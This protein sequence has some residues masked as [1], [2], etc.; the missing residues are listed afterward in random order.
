MNI[1]GLLSFFG[2]RREGGAPMVLV[3]V[4]ETRGSTYSKAGAQ[5]LIDG[6]GRFHGM[7]SGGCLEGDLALRAA[8]VIDTGESMTVEYDL[9]QDDD[10]WGLGVGCD[11]T[12]FVFL[13]RLSRQNGYR[14]FSAIASAMALDH[15]VSLALIIESASASI[16]AGSAVVLAGGQESIFGLDDESAA[17]LSSWL[18]EAGG[19]CAGV[20]VGGQSL[21]ALAA[22]LEPP[23]RLLVP[24]AGLDAEPVVRLAC[25]MDGVARSSI[26][27]RRMLIA[28]TSAGPTR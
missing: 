20:N 13:Q 21:T 23:H 19:G 6:E 1:A 12:M 26:I 7:L 5:M 16:A 28:V 27:G 4:Y 11:G 25:E 18:H 22:R 9:S 10:L 2:E 24:G 14:P 8:K 15:P 3:T 17:E